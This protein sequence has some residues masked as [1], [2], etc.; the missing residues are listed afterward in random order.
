M[1]L[2]GQCASPFPPGI[3]ENLLKC[4]GDNPIFNSHNLRF[5]HP[6]IHFLFRYVR[7]SIAIYL[8]SKKDSLPGLLVKTNNYI[9]NNECIFHNSLKRQSH[10]IF[11]LCFFS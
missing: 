6:P 1:H 10:E 3:D 4:K 7:N 8:A 9:N 5:K 11:D 2:L